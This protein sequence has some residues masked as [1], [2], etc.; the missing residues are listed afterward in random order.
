MFCIKSQS[1][2]SFW[3]NGF[4]KKYNMRNLSIWFLSKMPV[5]LKIS[6]IRK[7]IIIITFLLY[8]L[9]SWFE[10]DAESA[11][12]CIS[13]CSVCPPLLPCSDP[14]KVDAPEASAS[15]SKCGRERPDGSRVSALRSSSKN[16][17]RHACI[18]KI[19]FLLS[20]SMNFK[21][22]HFW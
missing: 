19:Y 20:F 7:K 1:L 10:E 18:F 16:A 4:N 22:A 21:N 2:R 14:P 5:N 12:D 6:K 11:L 3:K 15:V 13:V 9:A 17:W 8:A